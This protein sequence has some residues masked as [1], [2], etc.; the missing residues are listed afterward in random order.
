MDDFTIEYES[1]FVDYEP[2]YDVL[3]FQMCSGDFVDDVISAL[4]LFRVI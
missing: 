2:E 3:D 1:F 4:L